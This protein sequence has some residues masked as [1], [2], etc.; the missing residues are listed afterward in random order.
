MSDA[1]PALNIEGY[2]Q[3]GV[4]FLNAYFIG[5][6]PFSFD[7]AVFQISGQMTNLGALPFTASFDATKMVAGQNIFVTTHALTNNGP[8]QAATVTLLPQTINGTVSA[9]ASQLPILGADAWLSS[10]QTTKLA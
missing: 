9:M 6:Q 8:F 2:D 3:Q 7:T 1:E 10:P 5:S 4:D